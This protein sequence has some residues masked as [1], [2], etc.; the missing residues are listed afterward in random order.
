MRK[1]K[2]MNKDPPTKLQQY[3]DNRQLHVVYI[4]LQKPGTDIH[5][6]A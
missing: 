6:G 3:S 1:T 5:R 4:N 2:E